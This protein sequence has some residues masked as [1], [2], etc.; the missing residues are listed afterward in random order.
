[1]PVIARK[2][3]RAKREKLK[4]RAQWLKEAQQAFNA[5]I[6]LRDADKPCISCGRHH[7]GQWYAGHYLSTGARPELR[8]EPLNVHKQCSAC[9]THLSG[10]LVLYRAE[11]V[12]RIVVI[13]VPLSCRARARHTASILSYV[14]PRLL[15]CRGA[16]AG[17]A[18]LMSTSDSD[19]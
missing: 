4:S 8:F 15:G 1:M 3:D 16:S 13:G 9:N 14:E 2:E 6:R 19:T 5:W 12:R 10:N 11:L 18:G 17:V 7:E